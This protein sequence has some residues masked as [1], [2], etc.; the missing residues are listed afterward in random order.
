[1]KKVITYGSFDL[2]HE[3]HYKLLKRAKE[4]GDYLIV[5]VTTE[6]YDETRGKLNLVDSLS[7]RIENVKKTGFADEVIVEDHLGQKVEDIQKYKIDIFTVGSDW[8]GKFE[9]LRDY[10]D[11][12]YLPRTQNISSTELRQSRHSIIKLGII[13]TGRIATRFTKEASFVSGVTITSIYNPHI[14]SAER[15]A[16]QFGILSFTDDLEKF[17]SEI[18][19]VYIASPH[20]THYEYA[21]AALQHD[22]HVLSEKPLVFFKERAV[23]LYGLAREKKCVLM[24]ALKTAY[25]PGFNQLL[26]IARSGAIGAIRDV[27]ATF[28]R[29]IPD[30]GREKED[31]IYGGSFTEYGTYALLPI[32]K[33]MGKDF[34]DVQFSSILADNGIDLYTKAYFKYEKGMALAKTGVGVKSEGQLL[35]SGTNGYILAPSP[36]WLTK[37]F[38]VRY[39]DSSKVD[40]Y[41]TTFL[42]QGLRYELSDFIYS[43]N[44]YEGRDYKLTAG[45]S[46]AMAEVYEKF[47]SHREKFVALHGKNNDR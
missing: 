10:C 11:V 45:E 37:E 26:G 39:E 5:G 14:E 8:E 9:Y 2:F 3:G 44:G 12:V 33:L 30:G 17:F 16:N 47:M 36:W 27:E 15:F 6:Q 31:E 35:I 38:E 42:G 43:I 34:K 22:K 4:L 18:D 13:G 41:T 25:C 40:K 7:E 28:T 19:A 21:K 20:G 46:I 32:I 23:E 24:E 1:M 29:L